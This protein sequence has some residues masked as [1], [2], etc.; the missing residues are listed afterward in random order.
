MYSSLLLFEKILKTILDKQIPTS[1]E[2]CWKEKNIQSKVINCIENNDIPQGKKI[3]NSVVNI[4]KWRLLGEMK[5][6]YGFT[7]VYFTS[8]RLLVN[9]TVYISNHSL[10]Q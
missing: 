9:N 3:I 2:L 8:V 10:Y 6:I 1:I 7:Y 4:S 5:Y